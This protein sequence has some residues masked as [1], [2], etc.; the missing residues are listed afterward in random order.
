MQTRI[1][2]HIRQLINIRQTSGPLYGKSMSELPCLDNAWLLIEGEEI[3]GYGSM[4]GLEKELPHLP[5]EQISCHGRLVIPAWCDSHSHLV[6]SGSREQEMV[7][8]IR[9]MTYAEINARGGGILHTVSQMKDISEDALFD[10]SMERLKEVS[11]T[12]TG[13]I[14]I[15]SGYGLTMETELKMLRVIA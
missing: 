5:D 11:E 15:K 4:D 9:G 14:E 7:D 13:A 3:A 12:G 10:L 2:T 8:K 6:F 1:L